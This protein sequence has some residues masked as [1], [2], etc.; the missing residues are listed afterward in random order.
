MLSKNKFFGTPK[1]YGGK[2][3]IEELIAGIV[4]AFVIAQT[5]KFVINYKTTGNW[6]LSSFLQNGGMPSSHTATTVALTTGL[7]MET[8]LSYFVV[9]SALFTLVVMNDSMKVRRETGEEAKVLNIM[10]KKMNI[11]HKRLTE[12]VGHTP[13]QVAIGFVVGVASAL[14]IYSF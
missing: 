2:I 3:L 14:I 13:L 6:D 9:I 5:S 11:F 8:G 12:I 7:F 4:L 10:M 1:F